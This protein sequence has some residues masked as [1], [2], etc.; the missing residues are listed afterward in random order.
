MLDCFYKMFKKIKIYGIIVIE[1][2]YLLTSSLGFGYIL[3]RTIEYLT[4]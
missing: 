1:I 2:S 3:I 4:R